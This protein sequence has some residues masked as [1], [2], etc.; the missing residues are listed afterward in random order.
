MAKSML[1]KDITMN[2]I[3]LSSG[4]ERL[5]IISYG[6]KNENLMKWIKCELNGYEEG[7][8]LP[9]YRIV[10]NMNIIY[11]GINGAFNMKNVPLPWHY[12]PNE[13]KDTFFTICINEGIKTIEEYSTSE[14][15][16][17]GIDLTTFAPE[18]YKK[19]SIQCYSIINKIN[20]SHYKSV[21]DKVRF[22]LMEILLKLESNFGNIDDFDINFDNISSEKIKKVNSDINKLFS[23]GEVVD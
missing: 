15:L 13:L 23:G 20:I 21:V 17:L 11:S 19:T 6:M 16:K 12:I 14:N 3:S 7:D 9:S 8:H 10:K 22:N 18:V 4:L 1:I 2:K 5:Y